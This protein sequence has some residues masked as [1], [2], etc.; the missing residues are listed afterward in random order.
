MDDLDDN[1]DGALLREKE[2]G[3][4]W[5]HSVPSHVVD[6][7][8][9]KDKRRQEAINEVIYT[10]KDFVADLEYLR[11]VRIKFSILFFSFQPPFF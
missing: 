2:P 3:Q 5:V 11:D 8:S 9:D 1:N 7:M 10:E 6:G 4:L